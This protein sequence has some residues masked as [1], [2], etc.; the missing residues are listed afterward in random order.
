MAR[1]IKWFALGIVA[2]VALLVV[3]VAA[4]MLLVDPN[5]YRD[6][7]GRLVEEQTGQELVIEG[8]IRLSFFPWLGLDLGRTRLENRAGFGD[9][10]F[11]SIESAGVAV[12]LLPLL[13]REVVLDTIRLDGLRANLIVNEAGEANWEMDLPGGD[14]GAGE[15]S[16]PTAEEEQTGAEPGQLPVTIGTIQG[17]RVTDLHVTFED[18][19]TGARHEAGPVNLSLGE[20]LLGEDV[21]LEADW[22]ASLDEATRIEGSLEGLLQASSDLQRF[23]ANLTDL[24]IQTF[25]EGLPE[26]GLELEASAALDADLEQDTASLSEFVARVAGLQLDA[27]AE[28]TGL[29]TEPRVEGAF[30][31]PEADLRDTLER[32]E[33]EL[34]EM[35]DD[36][37][38]RRFSLDGSFTARTDSAEITDLAIHLDDT[39]LTGTAGIRDFATQAVRFDLQGD[40]LN[41]DRYLPPGTDDEGAGAETVGDA[42]DEDGDG[43]D[44]AEAAEIPLEP[45]RA[46]NLDGRVRLDELRV[47]GFDVSDIDINVT[48]AD[49]IIRI[50]PLVA[51]LYQG[52]YQGD[53]RLDATGEE[54][55]VSANER[56]NGVQAQ[57]IVT[58][59]LGRDLLRGRG[60]FRLQAETSGLDPMAMLRELVGEME[61]EFADGAV[62]GLNLAQ[63]VRN[64]GARLQGQ[65]A[66]EAEERTTDFTTLS[67]L[68]RIDQGRIRNEELRIQSPLF[69]V[70]GGGEANIFEQT[71]DYALT[72]N[73]VGTLEGQ[74]GE[75]LDDLR[76]VP[77]PLRFSGSLLSPDISLDLQEAITRQQRQRLQEEEE[78]L[79]ERAREEEERAR[80]RLDEERDEVEDK[81]RERTRDELRRFFD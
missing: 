55:R 1:V 56:L 5:D 12:Q 64:A 72:V 27:N 45:L 78:A 31:M 2:V 44:E 69:R 41:A 21:S 20:L 81:V 60:G 71:L 29:T 36:E 52:E 59:F 61:L 46:L 28:I 54:L 70:E 62:V 17:V 15:S 23:S 38:L 47:A 40:R 26:D 13:R 66:T 48:A 77:I 30:S 68:L 33:V 63:M 4:I 9:E 7:I 16:E 22:V 11:V 6:E 50:H 32:M 51:Q 24:R 42:G 80:E 18:R 76:R 43:G 67:A 57:P 10:P 3:L 19:Q 39:E 65:S 79:R 34:P 73:L 74:E 37:A 58:Q 14:Q 75:N 25:A 8:D 49:G 35:A 53:I